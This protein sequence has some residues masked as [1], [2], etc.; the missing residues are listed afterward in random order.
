LAGFNLTT[1]AFVS[2]SEQ[3]GSM[4]EVADLPKRVST[5]GRLFAWRRNGHLLKIQML[6]HTPATGPD[7]R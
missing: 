1:E 7:V 2:H 3:A 5:Y 6:D 4:Q